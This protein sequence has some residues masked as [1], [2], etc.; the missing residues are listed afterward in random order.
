MTEGIGQGIGLGV[1]ALRVA[2]AAKAAEAAEALAVAER[3]TQHAYLKHAGEFGN[4]GRS[5]FQRLVQETM[6]NP[7]EVPSLSNGRTAYWSDSQQMVVI[8]N[9]TAPTQSTAFRP[10]GGKS[11][12]DNLH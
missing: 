4:I 2:R 5:E 1:D 11:Y 3:V 9:G 10:S 6:S 7:S 8:E 12:F